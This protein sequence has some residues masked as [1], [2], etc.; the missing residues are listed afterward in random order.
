MNNQKPSVMKT[1]DYQTLIEKMQNNNAKVT[2]LNALEPSPI[3][4][5][6]IPHSL[7]ISRVRDIEHELSKDDDIVVYCSDTVCNQ[8]INLYHQLEHLGFK[9]VFRY[10]GGLR[11]WHRN[12]QALE[13][14]WNSGNSG[15]NSSP[16]LPD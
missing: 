1:I 2:L 4:R 3:R 13:E 10:P 7:N 15:M 12:G 5:L 16:S 6:Q 14:I 9:N 11:D 8:S